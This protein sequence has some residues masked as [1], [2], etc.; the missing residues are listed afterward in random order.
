[1]QLFQKKFMLIAAGVLPLLPFTG[2]GEPMKEKTEKSTPVFSN[3][4]FLQTRTDKGKYTI[5]KNNQLLFTLSEK[6]F[7]QF[8]DSI[9]LQTK[10]TLFTA[11][12]GKVVIHP[13][14]NTSTSQ[15][16][17]NKNNPPM[18]FTDKKGYVNLHLPQAIYFKYQVRF[19]DQPNQ[20]LFSIQ[21]PKEDKLVLEK[22]N[23]I[24]SGWFEYEV[25]QNDDLKEK[26]KIFLPK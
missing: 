23:F 24:R 26:G 7:R 19:F 2:N 21:S 9:A 13:Y 12:D 14:R 3:S 16:Q 1:M 22:S 11:R 25:W 6:A 4:Y 5:Y 17:V 20:L 18:V 10:D 15:T 8:R